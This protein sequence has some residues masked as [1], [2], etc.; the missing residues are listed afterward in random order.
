VAYS[1]G[2]TPHLR[3]SYIGAAPTGAASE[4]EY[5]VLR[6]TAAIGAAQTLELLNGNL[7]AEL[8]VLDAVV[9]P[10]AARRGF[11]D[12]LN[13]SEWQIELPGAD[14][15]QT[16]AAVRTL[17]GL[18]QFRIVQSRSGGPPAPGAKAKPPRE[19]DV[20]ASLVNLAVRPAPP[21]DLG[22]DANSVQPATAWP[23][24]D[25]R[26]APQSGHLGVLKTSA[27]GHCAILDAVLRHAT[28]A[29]RPGDVAAVLE[30]IGLELAAPPRA[31]R[32]TQ[33]TYSVETGTVEEPF[34]R[35]RLKA[36]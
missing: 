35:L 20:R 11:A 14:R 4:A 8:P 12:L 24:P 18:D 26:L 10:D 19:V 25:D 9:V 17:M 21:G 30:Q 2:F 3:L 29:V 28:P 7:P 33:G 27:G 22:E 15:D 6:L 5:L 34:S 32:L 13:A 31:T 1:A 23:A 36:S 16:E